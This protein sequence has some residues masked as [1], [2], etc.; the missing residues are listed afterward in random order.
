MKT[1]QQNYT[2]RI[3]MISMFIAITAVCSWISIPLAVPVTLQTFAVFVACGLLGGKD[4]TI[5][6]LAYTVIGAIGVPV[7]SGFT[8]GIGRLAGPTG[9]YIVGFICSALLIWLI[10]RLFGDGTIVMAIAMLTGLIACYAVGTAWF[11]IVYLNNTGA[12][13]LMSVLSMCVFPFIIPDILKISLALLL[14]KKL[15]RYF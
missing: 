5:T 15:K 13:S 14:T 9:G 11:M 2:K 3:A 8:G 12:I 6:L 10:T 1:N 7:F 4:G